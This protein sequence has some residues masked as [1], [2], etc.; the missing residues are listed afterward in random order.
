MEKRDLENQLNDLSSKLTEIK[1]QLDD[2]NKNQL[3]PIISQ[4]E[5]DANSL[6]KELYRDITPIERVQLAR[7]PN[8]P[9]TLDY[10]KFIFTDFIQFHG[11]RYFMDDGAIVGGVGFFDG[12][13]VTVIGH[14]KGRDTKDNIRR[15]FGCAHPEGY[16]KALRLMKQAEKFKRPVI[17]FID[18]QGAYPGLGAEERGQG[19]AIAVNLYEMSALKTPIISI[20]TGEGG[21]GGAL[22]LG[23]ADKVFML[24]N[25][26]YS[27][28]SPEGCASILWR[29]AAK[30]PDAA[31]AMKIDPNSLLGLGVIDDIIDEPNNGAHEDHKAT[32][33][34]IKEKIRNSLEELQ[35]YPL[36][37]LI[38]QRYR[39]FR[40]MGQFKE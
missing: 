1:T 35:Q 16:R 39:K 13:P 40:G 23:V 10:V 26:F 30:A 24:A 4:L 11:D 20:L 22:G 17:C 18:T 3:L 9:T 38:E 14:Q 7:H 19:E 2:K 31:K 15:H 12:R 6:R 8:R 36:D 5:N 37:V 29:D 32:A 27:V 21:S 28:I 33:D 34:N 25:T